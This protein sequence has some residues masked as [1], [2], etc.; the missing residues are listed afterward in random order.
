MNSSL[1]TELSEELSLSISTFLFS[2]ALSPK[3]FFL[4]SSFLRAFLA[5][6]EYMLF[7]PN[8]PFERLRDGVQS[9]SVS[10]SEYLSPRAT[11]LASGVSGLKGVGGLLQSP[12]GSE[13]TC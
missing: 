12:S 9:V 13:A 4:R 1:S 10:D 7:D 3:P 8:K 6:R 2:Y 5:F 11:Q